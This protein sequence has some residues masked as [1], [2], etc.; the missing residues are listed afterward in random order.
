MGPL[1]KWGLEEEKEASADRG[2]RDYGNK[3]GWMVRRG[4]VF[5]SRFRLKTL[6]AGIIEGIGVVVLT[7]TCLLI[8]HVTHT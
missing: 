6:K 3:T 2:V 7:L 1:A 4:L 8:R 5:F